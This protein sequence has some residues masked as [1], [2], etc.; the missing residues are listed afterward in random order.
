MLMLAVGLGLPVRC[1]VQETPSGHW[2]ELH[3]EADV[4]L[5][6][7]PGLAE[8]ARGAKG[9]GRTTR[10]LSRPK[11]VGDGQTAQRRRAEEIWGHFVRGVEQ[12]QERNVVSCG[13]RSM[14]R[15]QTQCQ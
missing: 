13:Y 12:R 7:V 2:R 8:P 5:R 3:S 11:L 14:R 4:L 10:D 15:L 9:H 1:G 6:G